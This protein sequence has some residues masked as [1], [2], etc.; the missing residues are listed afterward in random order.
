M[1]M[2][3][4]LKRA[5]QWISAARFDGAAAGG[6]GALGGGCGVVNPEALLQ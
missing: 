4:P 2:M 1:A 3:G 6:A 5:N